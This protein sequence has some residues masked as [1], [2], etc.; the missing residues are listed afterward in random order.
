MQIEISPQVAAFLRSLA[1]EP[2]RIIR[3][4]LR[5]LGEEKGDILALEHPPDGFYRLRVGRYRIIYRY[6]IVRGASVIRCEYAQRRELVYELFAEV[7][8]QLMN[9][10]KDK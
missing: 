7:V 10:L 1:P 3:S 2:R 5:D 8:A 6:A 9:E 4:A